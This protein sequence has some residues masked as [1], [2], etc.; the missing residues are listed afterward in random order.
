MTESGKVFQTIRIIAP[1]Q[2]ERECSNGPIRSGA[3]IY[4]ISELI[5]DYFPLPADV[6]LR[7]GS[8]IRA[9][10]EVLLRRCFRGQRNY[11][12]STTTGEQNGRSTRLLSK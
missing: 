7:A 11:G 8:D 5:G 6:D 9:H 3:R 2:K 1:T 4:F 12:Q 10:A